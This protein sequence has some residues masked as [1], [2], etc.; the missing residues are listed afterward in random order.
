[1]TLA[2]RTRASGIFR[3]YPPTAAEP[4]RRF[5]DGARLSCG[6]ARIGLRGVEIRSTI[7]QRETRVMGF[8]EKVRVLVNG[9]R[10]YNVV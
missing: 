7:V 9:G 4:C 8:L 5:S 1:M 6:A 2:P 3:G 10:V